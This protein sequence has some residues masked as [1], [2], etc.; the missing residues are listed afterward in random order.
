MIC[1]SSKTQLGCTKALASKSHYAFSLSVPKQS[2]VKSTS[3]KRMTCINASQNV[4]VFIPTN[5]LGNIREHCIA[6]FRSANT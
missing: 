5:W 2:G 6:K 3:Y 1:G 4:S